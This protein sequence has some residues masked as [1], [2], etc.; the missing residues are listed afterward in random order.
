MNLLSYTYRNRSED[1]IATCKL[2]DGVNL[3]FYCGKAKVSY[4]DRDNSIPRDVESYAERVLPK[5]IVFW[6]EHISDM[7]W[8]FTCECYHQETNDLIH[9]CYCKENTLLREWWDEGENLNGEHQILA[10]GWIV[11]ASGRVW[12]SCAGDIDGWHQLSEMYP[13]EIWPLNEVS[14]EGD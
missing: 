5:V 13:G 11:D 6:E 14:P 4:K 8:F 2:Q 9:E 10:G 7:L 1:W 3:N 12:E